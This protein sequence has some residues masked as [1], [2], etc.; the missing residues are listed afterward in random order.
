MLRIQENFPLKPLNT[1]GVEAFCTWFAEVS[2][3]EDLVQLF[4]D[5]RWKTVDRLILGGGSNV[6]FTKD[7]DGLVIKMSISGLN[8]SRSDVGDVI[9]EAGA[10]VVWSEFVTYC[11]DNGFAGVENLSL[12]PGSVGA[13]P[14]Q[15]IGAYGVELRDVFR[16]CRI[17][18]IATGRFSELSADDCGFG[19]RDSIFKRETKGNVVI[20]RV[21]F[22]LTVNR[23]VNISYGVIASEL[24]KRSID[25]P[26]IK[27]VSE[28]VSEI[29][30][31][32]LP[33][34]AIIGNAGSFFKNP[35]VDAGHFEHLKSIFPDIVHF[36]L[37][38]ATEKLAAG[39]MIEKA[40]WKGRQLGETGTW[41]NQ[42]LV[43]VNHGNATGSAIYELSTR[44]ISDVETLFG[45][46]LEREVNII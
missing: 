44:I 29:R 13:S 16:S 34:P 46:R 2:A 24:D 40:G 35:V 3:E 45:V 26:T 20:T 12:I 4:S 11:V 17:Y 15:N 36:S 42:A 30:L 31:S 39:W 7:F 19:Y 6:L 38:D 18:D 8:S 25:R 32:K 21:T 22:K 37:P 41:K 1:F 5:E 43:L 10:G 14:V 9:V 23:E 28:V 33:D 27:D